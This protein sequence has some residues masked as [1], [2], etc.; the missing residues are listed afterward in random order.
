MLESLSI[1]SRLLDSQRCILT[2]DEF[3]A[4]DPTCREFLLQQK[5]LVAAQNA[6]SIV[7]DA[8]HLDHVEL[9][10]RIRTK[11]GKALFR[12]YCP[13]SGSVD[14]PP[15]RLAQWTLDRARF[16]RLAN[17]AL[18][19]RTISKK[20]ELVVAWKIGELE[21]GGVTLEVI[22]AC[23]GAVD[24]LLKSTICNR[25]LVITPQPPTHKGQ[26]FAGL[27]SL[28]DAFEFVDGRLRLRVNSISSK[29]KDLYVEQP[30]KS[31]RAIESKTSKAV[32]PRSW[33]Q[34]ELNEAI[35]KYKADR[36][37]SFSELKD[38]VRRGQKDAKLSAQKLFGRN[39]IKRALG[40]KSPAMVT[41]SEVWQELADELLLAR[42]KGR[43][44]SR[45]KKIGFEIAMEAQA[46][47]VSPQPIDAAVRSETIRL[48]HSSLPIDQ[49]EPILEKLQ[50]GEITEDEARAMID[51]VK[52]QKRDLKTRR[53][54]SRP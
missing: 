39:V 2:G 7:C 32:P 29:L 6:T 20:L 10:D 17:A 1:I 53:T 18:P 47:E 31:K 41:N 36:S 33:I 12:I 27:I 37:S 52:E 28:N 35:R 49:S 51:L 30:K 44:A 25:T 15:N 3:L 48:V 38:A 22:L 5:L 21:I 19:S 11:S 23:L 14:V 45:L 46:S 4:I 40:V 34:T 50:R 26:E 13:E 54:K 43:N 16:V 24:A 9:V 42:G 8:C